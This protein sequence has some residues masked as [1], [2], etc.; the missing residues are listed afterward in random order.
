[1]HFFTFR[2]TSA[3]KIKAKD[4]SGLTSAPF[5]C[6]IIPGKM[7]QSEQVKA[8]NAQSEQVKAQNAQSEHVKGCFNTDLGYTSLFINILG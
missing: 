4:I 1:L 7:T 3:I 5:T 2:Y 8:Q 6:F